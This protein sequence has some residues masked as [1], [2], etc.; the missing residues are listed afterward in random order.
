[1]R[2]GLYLLLCVASLAHAEIGTENMFGKV[3]AGYVSAQ[4]ETEEKAAETLTSSPS[5]Q[6]LSHS[7]A[8]IK[9]HGG[10]GKVKRE[11]VEAQFS[12]SLKAE[13]TEQASQL[14]QA[15]SLNKLKFSP[16][17]NNRFTSH[18]E[19]IPEY[20]PVMESGCQIGVLENRYGAKLVLLGLSAV[21]PPHVYDYGEYLAY[22]NQNGTYAD[23]FAQL[24]QSV[25]AANRLHSDCYRLKDW[26]LEHKIK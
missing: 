14:N 7:E 23:D 21:S 10:S 20:F 18:N 24:S 9:I 25:H 4:F 13:N 26:I 1:M 8:N 22:R 16:N 11:Y 5:S 19:L 12:D 6:D 15:N 17:L 3:K 2:K